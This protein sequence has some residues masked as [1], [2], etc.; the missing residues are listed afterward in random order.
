MTLKNTAK[1]II[2]CLRRPII[3]K[4]NITCLYP[5]MRLADKKIVI[6]GGGRGLGAAMAEKFA[7]EGATVLVAGRNLDALKVAAERFHC[8]YLPLDVSKIETHDAF[9]EKALQILGHI[10]ILVNN[11]GISLHEQSFF[12]VTPESFDAQIST[13]L[14]G[15]FFLSQRTISLWKQ[16]NSKGTILFVSS[17]VGEMADFRPYGFSKG[18][19]NSMVQGLASLFASD[20]IRI[21]AIAPGITCSEMTGLSRTNDLTLSS[22]PLNRVYLPEEVA[23]TACFL[24]SEAAGCISGQIVS[25]NNGK[26]INTRWKK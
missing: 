16:L 21:V 24:V 25:C 23:E 3:T 10:D 20:G 15:P 14:K 17:E 26:S 7:N 19:I 9:L 22:N 11:A 1:K 8:Y 4:A 13:N 2:N 6:T 5:N 18:A 12:D